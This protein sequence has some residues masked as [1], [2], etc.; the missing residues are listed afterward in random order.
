M[1][2]DR[3][4]LSIGRD[5]FVLSRSPRSRE[6]IGWYRGL[7]HAA[8]SRRRKLSPRFAGTHGEGGIPRGNRLHPIH[9]GNLHLHALTLAHTRPE[10]NLMRVYVDE[11][12]HP[13]S[14]VHPSWISLTLLLY[15]AV[16]L[17]VKTVY[18]SVVSC[19]AVWIDRRKFVLEDLFAKSCLLFLLCFTS[20]LISL[21][22]LFIIVIFIYGL[23]RFSINRTPRMV[24]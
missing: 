10:S 17:E 13:L 15:L 11:L 9:V 4:R 23:K 2:I 21:S 16:F 19:M 1:A 24:K 20:C 14:S 3:G 6:P 12:R 8:A 22:I 7:D 5:P 18:T